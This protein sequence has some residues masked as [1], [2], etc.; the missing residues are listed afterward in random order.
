MSETFPVKS[1]KWFEN[2]SQFGYNEECDDGFFFCEVDL[3]CLEKLH[4]LRNFLSFLSERIKTEKVEK[5]VANL[6]DKTFMSLTQ[7]TSNKH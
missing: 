3:Q 7:R 4:D 5:L 2:A 1:F 6:H